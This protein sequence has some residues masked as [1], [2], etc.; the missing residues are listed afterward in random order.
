MNAFSIA[1]HNP[2][3]DTKRVSPMHLRFP[4][5]CCNLQ[6][7]ACSG[8]LAREYPVL[9]T[10]KRVLLHER[11]L[12]HD[13]TSTAGEIQSKEELERLR[14]VC[15]PFAYGVYAYSAGNDPCDD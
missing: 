8:R 2:L 12:V 11:V 13:E 1:R 9:W 15:A 4:A 14:S 3:T 5:G 10:C 7:R 6:S